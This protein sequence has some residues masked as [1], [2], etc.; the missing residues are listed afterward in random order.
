[1]SYLKIITTI[2][3]LVLFNVQF[4]KSETFTLTTDE[5]WNNA[6]EPSGVGEPD[7]GDNVII[8][9]SFT[10]TIDA[11]S[12]DDVTDA[13]STPTIGT[14]TGTGNGSVSITNDI[15]SQTVNIGSVSLA[16]GSV[17]IAGVADN[18]IVQIS[19]AVTI[20]ESTGSFNIISGP[21]TSDDF[22]D[23]DGNFS[24]AGDTTMMSGAGDNDTYLKLGGS[25]ISSSTFQLDDIGSGRSY[26][27]FDGTSNQIVTGIIDSTSDLNEGT[28]SV[29]NTSGTVTF[30]SLV[31]GTTPI[32]EINIAS[33]ANAIF[34][35]A[36]QTDKLDVT[37]TITVTGDTVDFNN[38]TSAITFAN[39]SKI[40]IDD[41]VSSGDTIFTFLAGTPT[42][43]VNST[44][45]QLP[46]T[47]TS[48]SI[49]FFQGSLGTTNFADTLTYGNL[50]SEL[51]AIN[52]GLTKYTVSLSSDNPTCADFGA[53]C[54]KVIITA[55]QQT[56]SESVSSLNLSSQGVSAKTESA[57]TTAWTFLTDNTSLDSE[58]YNAFNTAINAGGSTSAILA[59]QTVPQ[60][61]AV[62]GSNS[63]ISNVSNSSMNIASARL[64]SVRSNTLLAQ[65]ND[66]LVMNDAGFNLFDFKDS[67]VFFKT[68][69]SKTEGDSYDNISGFKADTY[70]FVLGRD[71][72]QDDGSRLGFAYSFSDS[73]VSGKGSGQSVTKVDTHQLMFYGDKKIDQFLFEGM[74][75]FSDNNNTASRRINQSGLNRVAIGKFNSRSI[76]TRGSLSR[77]IKNPFGEGVARLTF[78]ASASN[79]NNSSYTETGANSLNMN[80]NPD[81]TETLVGFTGLKFNKKLETQSIETKM[82]ELRLGASYD[83]AG[84]TTTSIASYTGGGSAFSVDG[85]PVDQLGVNFGLSYLFFEDAAKKYSLNYDAEI[86]DHSVSQTL[87][88]DFIYQF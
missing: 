11:N 53:A 67:Q 26:L 25:T 9:N 32:R 2:F 30:E 15:N 73:D 51:T 40:I 87:S 83:F 84:D 36:F 42:V 71:K 4:S 82:L 16:S 45:I 52:N 13:N 39:N 19:G 85:N 62:A 35:K 66:N 44:S 49:T 29:T 27:V 37:G 69:G 54:E 68:F 3:I 7:S 22:V 86:K 6:G 1:M 70:G 72:E 20:S 88:F 5:T 58:A 50:T 61:D 59:N 74:A 48:G 57:F 43:S 81:D 79:T 56:A 55:S 24:N 18:I 76:F 8:P 34:E 47:F 23:I 28:I 12:M 78:G 10:L 77:D 14:I 46:T 21:N 33:N 63:V 80:V 75:G 38:I 17:D 60:M 65:Y 41:N 31:G 64:A